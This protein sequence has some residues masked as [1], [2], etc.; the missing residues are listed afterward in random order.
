MIYQNGRRLL[1]PALLFVAMLGYGALFATPVSAQSYTRWAPVAGVQPDE[2]IVNGDFEVESGQV[3]DGNV[4]VYNGDVQ[5]EEGGVIHGSLVVYS[6]DI[7]I[8]EGGSIDGDVSA[9]SGDLEIAGNVG[10]SVAAWS[11]HVSLKESATVAGDISVLDSEI[12][13]E[14]GAVVGGNI[15]HG[16]KFNFTMPPS[17]PFGFRW[18]PNNFPAQVA[19]LQPPPLTSRIFGF[20]LRLMGA[21]A[22]SLLVTLL[23][24]VVIFVRPEMVQNARQLILNKTAMSFVTGLFSNLVLAFTALFLTI[25]ICLAPLA[26]VPLLILVVVNVAGWAAISLIAGQRLSTWINLDMQPLTQG[27]LG[28]FVL[29]IMTAPLWALG[30]CFR[31]IAFVA[32]L[33]LSSIGV[34]AVILPWLDRA[35][36][37]RDEDPDPLLLSVDDEG[38]EA[39]ADKAEIVAVQGTAD[40]ASGQGAEDEESVGSAVDL[41]APSALADDFT[42]LKG[43]GAVFAGRLNDAGILTFAQL[44]SLGADE[45][46]E[47]IG[48]PVERVKRT[49][50]VEQAAAL[51]DDVG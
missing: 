20:F 41:P 34:G 18:A 15:L 14:E 26:L 27:I 44:A 43:I 19:E 40:E 50:L 49:A 42:R 8:E 11:G 2:Q 5:V 51:A 37:G 4:V 22:T 35:R 23:V 25:T 1:L 3:I 36:N 16:P 9:F 31:F 7:D 10:G 39:A 30:G 38:D 33:L 17:T 46:A 32:I 24:G 21:I 28:A 6:G 12:D 48:W 47:I 13:R 29:L 45:I